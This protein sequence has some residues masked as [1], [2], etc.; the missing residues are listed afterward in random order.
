MRANDSVQ[1]QLGL[2]AGE[3]AARLARNGPNE[4]PRHK[5]KSLLTIAFGVVREPMFAMLLAAGGIYVVLGDFTESLVLLAFA[6]LSVVITIVQEGRSERV[7]AALRD[8]TSPRALV[9]RDGQPR[10]VAAR[11]VVEGDLIVVA[12]GDRVAADAELTS[13]N[14]VRAD[15]SLLTGESVPVRKRARETRAD[16]LSALGGDDTAAIFAGTLIVRGQGVAE[17]RAT[18]ARSRIGRIGQSLGSIESATPRLTQETRRAV[19]TLAIVGLACCVVAVLLFGML[20]GSWLEALL[21]GIALG[22]AMLPEEFPLVLTVFMAMGAWRLSRA[23]VLTRRA[24]AIETLGSATVLCTDKTGTLTENRMVISE[25]RTPSETLRFG[26]TAEHTLSF[27]MHHLIERGVLASSP[28]PFDPMEKAFRDASKRSGAVPER[29]LALARIYPLRPELLAVTQAWREPLAERHIVSAKGAPEAI[30][31]LCQLPAEAASATRQQA[32]EMAAQGQRVLGVAEAFH[33]TEPWPDSPK[34]FDFQFLGLVGLADPLRGNVPHA[35]RECRRAGIR[36]IMIT[37][38]YPQTARAIAQQA[39]LDAEL[40]LTGAQISSLSA[41]ELEDAVK[42]T[43]VFARIL[44]E[45]KLRLIEA[46]KRSGEVV[47]MTGD[48]VNDAPALRAADIGIAMGGRGTDVAREASSIV[49]LDDE[50]SSIGA[51]IRL[52]R[53][54]YDNLRKAMTYILAIHVPI[55]GMALLPLVTGWPIVLWPLHI[56]FLEMIIDPACSIVFEAEREEADIMR[57]PPRPTESKLLSRDVI[58]W[59]LVQGAVGLTVVGSIFLLS[60]GSGMPDPDVRALTFVSLVLVNLALVLVNLSYS[61]DW[62]DT[63]KRTNR[64]LLFIATFAVLVIAIAIFWL[65]AA[66][67]FGFGAFHLHDFAICVFAALTVLFLL[68]GIK[69]VFRARLVA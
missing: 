34:S 21:A 11:E 53:R 37:G 38:D 22:M 13:S 7:L 45:Q 18:G 1:T 24:A 30:I 3:A 64:A 56:A 2:S 43:A 5:A 36:V 9:I 65:P 51:T 4:L 40:V 28:E 49:L 44:P 29:N 58:L 16:E 33:G 35:V 59:G 12:E 41:K 14:D 69:R 68:E 67:S 8:L 42:R 17:V 52:G 15:E 32:N 23:R 20:R 39:G 60:A 62:R 61:H 50:F 57:R 63:F 6:S 48:G 54:I 66:K 27:A 46:L 25:L 10:R 31:E 47:A 26:D 19:R 55:A